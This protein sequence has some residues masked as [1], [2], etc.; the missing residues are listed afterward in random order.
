MIFDFTYRKEFS[1]IEYSNLYITIDDE[2]NVLSVS[3]KTGDI[4]IIEG[5]LLKDFIV[6]KKIEVYNE[7]VLK[8]AT[9]LI[10]LLSKSHIDFKPKINYSDGSLN[11]QISDAFKAKFGKGD[12][13]E[14]KF[15]DFVDIYEALVNKGV[16]SGIIDVSNKGLPLYKPFGE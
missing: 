13:I 8:N 3:D 2:L 14:R 15:N 11:V 7:S 16:N 5:F 12:D 6:G 10:K 1:V 9:L 4:F